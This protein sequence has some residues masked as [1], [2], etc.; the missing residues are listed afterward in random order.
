MLTLAVLLRLYYP[1]NIYIKKS[2]LKAFSLKKLIPVTD[3]AVSL[4]VEGVKTN[5]QKSCIRE[6][7]NLSTRAD[8]S[9]DTKKK[10][11][12]KSGVTCQV[13][14]VRCHVS[15]VILGCCCWSWPRSI[16]NEWQRL[17][18]T[19]NHAAIINHFWAQIAKSETHVLSSLFPEDSVCPFSEKKNDQQ[20]C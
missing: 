7:L 12:K 18:Q 10:R 6:T 17:K 4:A 20:T 11:R 3:V 8:S 1:T 13:S 15:G 9:T 2:I 16:N 19:K 5:K 14:L